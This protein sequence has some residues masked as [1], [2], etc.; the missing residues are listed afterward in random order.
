MKKLKEIAYELICLKEEMLNDSYS[1]TV[2]QALEVSVDQLLAKGFID[3]DTQLYIK[4][5]T[6]PL[7]SFVEYVHESEMFKKSMEELEIEYDA[8]MSILNNE[9]VELGISSE[10]F[11]SKADIKNERIKICKIFCLREDFL[12]NYFYL[13]GES[14]EDY[15][16][17]L[18]KRKG[19]IEKFAVLRLPRILFNFIDSCET[20]DYFVL[21]KT[22]PYFDFNSKCYSIDLVFDINI[23]DIDT[24]EKRSDIF[25]ELLQVINEADIYFEERL[26]I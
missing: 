18:M 4:D 10:D 20:N 15:L 23:D 26:S 7:D 19:F 24:P 21:E 14:D 25:K 2:K 8:F 13:N 5:R 9:I 16:E 17:K 11:Y 3:M 6:Y 22:Y 12:K 1:K